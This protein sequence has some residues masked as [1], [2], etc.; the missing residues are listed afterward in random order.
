MFASAFGVWLVVTIVVSFV[1]AKRTRDLEGT[2]MVGDVPYVLGTA[3]AIGM[4]VATCYVLFL[5]AVG[6]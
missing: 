1:L 5:K 6:G 3:T 4:V 2:L